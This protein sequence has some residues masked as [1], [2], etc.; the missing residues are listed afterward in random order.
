MSLDLHV[1]G[2][3]WRDHLVRTVESTPGIVP[4]AKGNGYGLGLSLAAAIANLHDA[5][6]TITDN[7]PGLRV[8]VR[9][10]DSAAPAASRT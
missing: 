5:P 8:S 7:S 10:A 2:K 9:L 4:V 6:L 1:D 3:L